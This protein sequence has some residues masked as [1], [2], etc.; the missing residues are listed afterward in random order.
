MAATFIELVRLRATSDP[1]V[2]ISCSY[3]E[4][5]GNTAAIAYGGCVQALV[6][7]AAFKS[8]ESRKEQRN[9]EIYS[10]LGNFLGPTLSDR[11]VKI[12]VTH[13]RDTRSFAT[14]FVVASQ[15]QN[16]GSERS[17]FSALVDFVAP[18]KIDTS[19]AGSP[20]VAYSKKPRMQYA[21]P[22]QLPTMRDIV[23]RKVQERKVHQKAADHFQ[24][25]VFGLNTKVVVSAI[26]PQGLHAH[27]AIG[28]DPLAESE[29]HALPLTDRFA[30]DWSKSKHELASPPPAPSRASLPACSYAEA[31]DA[32]SMS[33]AS[34]NA[35]LVAFLMDAALSFIPLTFSKKSLADAAVAS[36]LD[37]A[38]R[39]FKPA[40]M[41]DFHLRE[42]QT[43]A[44]GDCRTYSEACLWDRSQNLVA[45]MTQV[46][47]L[48]PHAQ[49]L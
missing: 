33:P 29:Q 35:S 25:V 40:D 49:K 28:L 45:C 23:L 21:P 27:N 19:H 20:F 5:M 13:V 12:V 11:N 8:I 31:G 32:M 46:C 6:V 15:V 3:P 39:F 38:L 34:A 18:N 37:T 14:R 44:G 7:Q 42:M 48:R 10:L 24:N 41:D 36:S 1:N 30:V 2:Y 22:E 16:D 26:P 9:F 43:H 47:V 17:T 4:K